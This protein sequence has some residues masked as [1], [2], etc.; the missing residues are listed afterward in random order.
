M[1]DPNQIA[2]AADALQGDATV[3]D[4]V[5]EKLSTAANAVANL[6][7]TDAVFCWKGDALFASYGAVVDAVS[8]Y[9]RDGSAT[10]T[11]GATELRNVRE[12][13]LRNE[14]DIVS[15]TTGLWEAQY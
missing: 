11:A 10:A 14:E 9:L 12:L 15:T 7:S 8:A 3:W 6:R 2:V 13:F 1:A 4:E 5:G